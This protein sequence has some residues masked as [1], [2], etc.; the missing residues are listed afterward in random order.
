LENTQDA[1]QLRLISIFHYIVAG[2]AGL[3]S[4]FPLVHVAVGI[5]IITGAFDDVNRGGSPPAIIG[6][7]FVLL[8]V[9]VIVMGLTLATCIAVAG[10]KLGRR[11][12]HLY[13]LIVAGLE[14]M[15]MP[16]GT[17]LGILT[18]LVLQRPT[19]KLLFEVKA[20]PTTP[21]VE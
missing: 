11:T 16:F 21:E 8:A 17:V 1:D 2:I 7:L 10:Q 19:V 15:F 4:L 9:V 6:W 20:D 5:G 3:F 14:C 13:C 18:I 12:G